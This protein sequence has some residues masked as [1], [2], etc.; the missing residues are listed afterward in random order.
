MAVHRRPPVDGP[1]PELLAVRGDDW[2][3]D[4]G[5]SPL[6][7]GIAPGLSG[8]GRIRM[9]SVWVGMCWTCFV[10]GLHIGGGF[11]GWQHHYPYT[12]THRDFTVSIPETETPRRA[13]PERPH[14]KNR[15]FFLA[16]L[17]SADGG[18]IDA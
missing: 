1:P 4:D 8:R 18:A 3:S 11:S 12:Y 6:G 5:V 7:S 2:I 15:G 16:S 14:K 9:I 10:G 17:W 13:G